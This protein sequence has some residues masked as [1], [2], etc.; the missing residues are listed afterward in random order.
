[1]SLY[2]CAALAALLLAVQ[3]GWPLA[4]LPQAALQQL[5]FARVVPGPG[6]WSTGAPPAAAE[7][8]AQPLVAPHAGALAQTPRDVQLELGRDT[9]SV[10]AG[11]HHPAAAVNSSVWLRN[12]SH[13]SSRC[14]MP[15]VESAAELGLAKLA[16]RCAGSTT[17]LLIR[18]LPAQSE[19]WRGQPRGRGS[20]SAAP[21]FITLC[22]FVCDRSGGR[23][24]GAAA[25]DSRRATVTV[26]G[27]RA[28]LLERFGG[29]EVS[30]PT[31]CATAFCCCWPG[32]TMAAAAGGTE[33]SNAQLCVASGSVEPRELPGAGPG[34][35]RG[36]VGPAEA[37]VYAPG[38][39]EVHGWDR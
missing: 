1:M 6:R 36:G 31:A 9:D 25:R 32:A 20:Q 18:G 2:T 26:F 16:R 22:D 30:P 13:V 34:A 27:D 4:F 10:L 23:L 33:L 39:G 35:I 12:A 37:R 24:T 7:A 38:L 3:P 5:A 14:T 21:S 19:K 11:P 28:S 8:D 29:E 15:V 17:P